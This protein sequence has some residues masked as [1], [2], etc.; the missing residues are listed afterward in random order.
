[1]AVPPQLAEQGIDGDPVSE[2]LGVNCGELM[3]AAQQAPRSP[4][5]SCESREQASGKGSTAA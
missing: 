2:L 1:M 5:R 3:L 4:G